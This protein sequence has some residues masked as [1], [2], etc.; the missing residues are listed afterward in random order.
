LLNFRKKLSLENLNQ[1]KVK[2]DE[3]NL[4]DFNK[5]IKDEAAGAQENIF[6]QYL[7]EA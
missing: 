5:N 3:T 2:V 7:S 1:L 4:L 6:E